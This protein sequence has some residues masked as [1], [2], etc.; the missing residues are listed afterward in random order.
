[1]K[2]SELRLA[3]HLELLSKGR[4]PFD[5]GIE[6]FEMF[7]SEERFILSRYGT[8]LQALEESKIEPITADQQRFLKVCCGEVEPESQF[9]ILWWKLRKRQEFE[10]D[11]L[12]PPQGISD[13]AQLNTRATGDWWNRSRD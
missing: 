8:W 4:E 7:S 2:D 1:M 13:A 12:L 6:R 5:L 9:E 10:A 3:A 11:D